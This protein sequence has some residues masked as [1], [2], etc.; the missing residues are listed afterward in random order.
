VS[1]VI[2][3]E[4]MRALAAAADEAFLDR[5]AAYVTR[6]LPSVCRALGA[7]ATRERVQRA[8][9]KAARHGIEAEPDVML[10]VSLVF[11]FGEDFEQ[12]GD[13]AWSRAILEDASLTGELKALTLESRLRRLGLDH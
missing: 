6:E 11:R 3:D 12:G 1:L 7:A 10:V 4:Q 5:A 8:F 2:R 9:D 13:L